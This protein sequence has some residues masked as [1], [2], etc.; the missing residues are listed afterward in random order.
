MP[1]IER[2]L[3]QSFAGELNRFT[4]PLAMHATEFQ[5]KVWKRLLANPYGHT[6]SYAAMPRD[7]GV[8]DDHRADGRANG[9]NQQAGCE[10][11]KGSRMA[12]SPRTKLAANR[13]HHIVRGSA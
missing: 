11:I 3:Q 2:E 10:G 13:V 6:L 9:D 7:I 8:N 1:K 5:M 4:E 12:D